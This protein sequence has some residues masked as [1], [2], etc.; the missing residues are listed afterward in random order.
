MPRHNRR[1]A[2]RP[3]C[4]YCA[5]V[6]SDDEFGLGYRMVD[7]APNVSFLVDTMDVVASWGATIE[8]RR[9]ERDRLRLSLGARLIDV[10]CGLGDAA[11]ALADHLGTTGEI[12]GI[13]VSEEMIAVA[14]QRASTA[15]CATQF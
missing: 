6:T 15:C 3:R 11:L 8:L 4:S 12:V 14:R 5:S 13:D 9:W 2:G 10:R 1:W 7:A